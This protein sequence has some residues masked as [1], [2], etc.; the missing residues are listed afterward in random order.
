M[1][2]L[3][4]GAVATIATIAAVTSGALSA[5]VARVNCRVTWVNERVARIKAEQAVQEWKVRAASA[6]IALEE[7]RLKKVPPTLDAKTDQLV[8]LAMRTDNPHES[9]AAALAVCR[10]LAKSRD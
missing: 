4:S 3:S 6:E 1:I 10:R 2:M 5:L 9:A 7:R 8:R